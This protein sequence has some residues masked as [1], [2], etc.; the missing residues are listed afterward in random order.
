MVNIRLY[1]WADWIAKDDALIRHEGVLSLSKFELIEAIEERGFSTP[2][3]KLNIEGDLHELRDVL[4]R[5][6]MCA[7]KVQAAMTA[8]QVPEAAKPS[9]FA[10]FL[11]AY[12]TS[13]P[14]A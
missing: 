13:R 7:S 1:R 14:K 2:L 3:A 4:T 5:Y 6:L 8:A 9:V 10:A 12:Q 11:I